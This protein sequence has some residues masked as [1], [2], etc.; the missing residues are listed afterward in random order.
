MQN[1]IARFFTCKQS[2][3]QA[4]RAGLRREMSAARG[5]G[6]AMTSFAIARVLVISTYLSRGVAMGANFLAG[7]ILILLAS[8]FVVAA[9]LKF[10]Y[11]FIGSVILISG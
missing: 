11:S 4:I 1:D 6:I 7:F 9:W 2:G 5:A 8:Q 3:L 10:E